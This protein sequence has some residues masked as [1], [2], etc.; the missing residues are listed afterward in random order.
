MKKPDV[1]IEIG[2]RLGI[3]VQASWVANG[4]T[5]TGDWHR[6]VGSVLG[7]PFTSDKPAHMQA[8]L[9]SLGVTWDPA[10]HES[11]KNPLPDG[12]NLMK[13][14]YEDLLAALP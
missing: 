13:A 11:R 7:I 2:R 3:P 14:A 9:T 12:D 4:E 1:A 8:M 10:R 6:A 5:I